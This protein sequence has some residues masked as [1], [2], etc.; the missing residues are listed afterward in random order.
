MDTRLRSAEPREISYRST[1]DARRVSRSLSI[2][3]IGFFHAY[4]DP[5]CIPRAVALLFFKRAEAGVVSLLVY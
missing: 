5:I 1:D 2:S 4:L 3:G